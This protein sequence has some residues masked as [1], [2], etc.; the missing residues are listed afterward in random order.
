MGESRRLVQVVRSP[1]RCRRPDWANGGTVIGSFLWRGIRGISVE[2]S[3]APNARLILD[4]PPRVWRIDP[5]AAVHTVPV[6]DSRAR[7]RQS[8]RARRSFAGRTT[9]CAVACA[10]GAGGSG[11]ACAPSAPA[12]MHQ[13]DG[14][15]LG[16]QERCRTDEERVMAVDDVS[17]VPVE[18]DRARAGTQGRCRDHP[19]SCRRHGQQC[20]PA[21]ANRLCARHARLITKS[22]STRTSRCHRGLLDAMR[23]RLRR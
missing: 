14:A 13:G 2:P 3:L 10:P 8:S 22:G 11:D 16:Q 15:V 12:Q 7:H 17:D 23:G 5:E 4:V 9:W 19:E 21:G 18:G 20:R 6:H 1:E